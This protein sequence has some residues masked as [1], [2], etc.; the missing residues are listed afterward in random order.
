MSILRRMGP[1]GAK[2]LGETLDLSVTLKNLDLSANMLGD[3][4]IEFMAPAIGRNAALKVRRP[5]SLQVQH[6]F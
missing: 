3:E 5:L 4:G 6:F 1:E 2:Y